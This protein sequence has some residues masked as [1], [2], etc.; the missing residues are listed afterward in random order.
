[1]LCVRKMAAGELW[2]LAE[3]FDYEDFAAEMAQNRLEMETGMLDIFGLYEDERLMG[4]LHVHHASAR[5]HFA[6][7]GV[8]AYLFA[9]RIRQ[10]AQGKGLGKHLLGRTLEILSREGYREF[11]VGVEEDNPR[12]MHL[13]RRYGFTECISREAE[14]CQGRRYEYL[15]YLKKLPSQPGSV[16]VQR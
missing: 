12:A 10:E 8:R 3:L 16:A 2:Q 7:P 6:S 11:T 4:E 1:M 15:L 5:P 13:Y 14:T 9:F